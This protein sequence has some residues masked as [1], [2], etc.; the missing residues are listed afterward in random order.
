MS[1]RER[2]IKYCKE[3]NKI[4]PAEISLKLKIDFGEVMMITT[5]LIAEGILETIEPKKK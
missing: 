4:R 5:A 3:K 1:N 2:I